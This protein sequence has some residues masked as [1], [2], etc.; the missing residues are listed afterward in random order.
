[1]QKCNDRTMNETFEFYYHGPKC[2]YIFNHINFVNKIPRH[3]KGFKPFYK[4]HEINRTP[5][6]SWSNSKCIKLSSL[7]I[8]RTLT[9]LPFAIDLVLLILYLFVH[10]EASVF[11]SFQSSP[12]SFFLFLSHLLKILQQHQQLERNI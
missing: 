1:M 12:S 4:L 11:Q 2:K 8:F 9:M 10:F 3:N 7:K 5:Y 6:C